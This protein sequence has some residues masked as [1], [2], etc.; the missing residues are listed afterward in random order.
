[1]RKLKEKLF[2]IS[3]DDDPGP[4]GEEEKALTC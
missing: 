4:V 2:P 3:Q 1:M